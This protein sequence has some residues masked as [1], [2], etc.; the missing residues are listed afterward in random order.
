MVHLFSQ[1]VN[2]K[3]SLYLCWKYWHQ[4]SLDL[5]EPPRKRLLQLDNFKG[6]G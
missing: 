6:L 4:I 3:L 1:T 2:P 5:R